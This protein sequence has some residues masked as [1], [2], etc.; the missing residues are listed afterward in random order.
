MT[1][2]TQTTAQTKTRAERDAAA[3]AGR[4]AWQDGNLCIS[5]M[6]DRS[7]LEASWRLGW[8]KEQGNT[9]GAI[10]KA[11]LLLEATDAQ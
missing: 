9:A 10:R 7:D 3:D 6:Y 4:K 1:D 8:R 2:P 5:P 11:A